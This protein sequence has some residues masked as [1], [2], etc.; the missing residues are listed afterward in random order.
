MVATTEQLGKHARDLAVAFHVRLIED[1][2]IR[3]EEALSLPEP[4][5]IALVS[6]ILDETTYAVALHEMG[7]LLAPS[8]ILR[9]VVEGN[10]KNLMR[11]EEDAAWQWAKHYALDW[12]PA[13]DALA[14]WA[15]GTYQPRVRPT[16]PAA[17]PPVE[18][19]DWSRYR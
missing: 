15:E 17:P 5:K 1:A 6:P 7:H 13:M 8:G 16:P 18:H 19:V 2:R 4:R 3:P 14:T 9:T 10:P 12:T 11:L